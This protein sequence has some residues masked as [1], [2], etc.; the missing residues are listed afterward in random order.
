MSPLSANEW[1]LR[2]SLGFIDQARECLG[3]DVT[4]PLAAD[5]A[6]R[7]GRPRSPS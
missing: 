5:A 6:N 2:E 3:Y 7:V 1:D 4:V